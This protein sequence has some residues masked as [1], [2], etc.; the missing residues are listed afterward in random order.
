MKSVSEQ[1]HGA[2][3]IARTASRNR[4]DSA[5]WHGLVIRNGLGP[6]LTAPGGRSQTCT[7]YSSSDG[8]QL[9]LA[10]RLVVIKLDCFS[11]WEALRA[12]T[13]LASL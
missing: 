4:D 7:R 12:F 1:V 3:G 5:A 11:G 10:A 8:N 6:Q 13:H 2:R 9:A